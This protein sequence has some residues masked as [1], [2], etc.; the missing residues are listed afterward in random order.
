MTTVEVVDPERVVTK[1]I[2]NAGRIYLGKDMA[3]TSVELV[4]SVKDDDDEHAVGA[5]DL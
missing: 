5:V 2:D 1:E 3:G 4:V